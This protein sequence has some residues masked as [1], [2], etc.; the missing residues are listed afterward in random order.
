M[1]N[2]KDMEHV[3]IAAQYGTCNAKYLGEI[4]DMDWTNRTCGGSVIRWS[5]NHQTLYVG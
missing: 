3:A 5:R 1:M 4:L 2:E